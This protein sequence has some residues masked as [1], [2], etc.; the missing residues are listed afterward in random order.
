[1][2]TQLPHTVV[3]NIIRVP[4]ADSMLRGLLPHEI[5]EGLLALIEGADNP[6]VMVNLT[7]VEQMTSVTL[8]GLLQS[9]HRAEQ[10][11]GQMR[12]CAAGNT[13]RNVL[14]MTHLDGILHLD[15]NEADAAAQ[16]NQV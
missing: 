13:I 1:M 7:D 10:E 12:L 3:D 8:A 15:D 6:R 16:L 11:G 2:P 4:L 9:H 14:H 5:S